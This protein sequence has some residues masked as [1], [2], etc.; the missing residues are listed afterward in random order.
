[1]TPVHETIASRADGV[2]PEHEAVLADSVGL[3]LL[4]RVAS[5]LNA[6]TFVVALRTVDLRFAVGALVVIILWMS[7]LDTARDFDRLDE[8]PIPV[9]EGHNDYVS[10]LSRLT[11]RFFSGGILMFVVLAVL[12]LNHNSIAPLIP[13]IFTYFVIGLVSLPGM[14]FQMSRR[15]WR[16]PTR[17][18]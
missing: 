15:R 4:V 1:M 2:D 7:A 9:V 14:S 11:K 16:S 10:P 18:W 13:A 12:T 5:A 6:G 8:P 17:C 3:A